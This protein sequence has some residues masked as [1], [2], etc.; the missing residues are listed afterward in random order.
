MEQ[1]IFIS[2]CVLQGLA[3]FI[4]GYIAIDLCWPKNK[5]KKEPKNKVHFYVARDK[6]SDIY[7]Y[8]GK[9]RR[10]YSNFVNS[11]GT[12]GSFVKECDFKD[13]GLNPDDFKDLK[14]EDEPVEVFLN[15]ED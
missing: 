7:L 11:Y 9:P 13:F 8:L 6:N 14:W 1:F 10:C 5:Y 15:L 12:L 4:I 3:F 2:Y